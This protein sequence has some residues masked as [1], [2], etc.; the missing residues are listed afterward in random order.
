MF[1]IIE[2]GAIVRTIQPYSRL[3]VGGKDYGL[4]WHKDLPAEKLASLGL[5]EVVETSEPDQRFYWVGSQVTLVNGVPTRVYTALPKDLDQ[6]KANY[7]QQ[8][9]QNANASLTQT[10]WMV[11]RKAE[12]GVDIPANV[13]AARAQI[14]AD[15][16]AR[17]DAIQAANN[18]EELIAA[19]QQSESV[20]ST[21]I[22]L[23]AGTAS[24]VL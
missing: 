17:E 21:S 20:D 11:I 5:V 10:D 12:R 23:N 13:A 22:D 3:I 6:L 2:N 19:T 24:G 8:A 18:V 1:A 4:Y 16:T 14:I 9:K 7:I 15:C